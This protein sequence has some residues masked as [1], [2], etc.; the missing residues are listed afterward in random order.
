MSHIGFFGQQAKQ[1]NTSMN[2]AVV[3]L[4]LAF[5]LVAQAAFPTIGKK[6][7]IGGNYKSVSQSGKLTTANKYENLFLIWI[8]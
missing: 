3:L 1:T 7:Y 8:V 4:L 6:F 5:C 2:K